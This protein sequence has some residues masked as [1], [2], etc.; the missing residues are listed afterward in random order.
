MTAGTAEKFELRWVYQQTV[1]RGK[2]HEAGQRPALCVRGR[3]H[4]LCV[5]AGYPVHVLK[6][7]VEAYDRYRVVNETPPLP[8]GKPTPEGATPIG[9]R[10]YDVARALD[11]LQRL[12]ASHGITAGAR[13]LMDRAQ[14]W[15]ASGSKSDLKINDD[16]F[17]DEEEMI[18]ENNSP[19]D[20]PET[21][22]KPVET[23]T[24]STSSKKSAPKKSAP[25]KEA[26]KKAAPK[27][28]NGNGHAKPTGKPGAKRGSAPRPGSMTELVVQL[29]KAGKDNKT[30]GK[31]IAA[32][33]EFAGSLFAKEVKAGDFHAVG[34]YQNQARKRGWLPKK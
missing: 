9:Q 20:K 5:C 33:K 17:D 30:I 24:T 4:A 16:E 2:P 28:A 3:K 13:K 26:A 27:K 32:K 22:E 21:K 19:V 10:P 23:A 25:K 11:T 29:T 6:R 1:L 7:P 34:Y 18:V 15:V 31:T 14:E 8:D 12:V